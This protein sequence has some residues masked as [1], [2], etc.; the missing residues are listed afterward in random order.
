MNTDYDENELTEKI[1]GSAYNVANTLGYGFLEKV[2]ENSMVI[3]LQEMGLKVESQVPL[4]VFYK[5]KIVGEYVADLIVEDRIV[6]ELKSSKDISESYYA[7]LLNYLKACNKKLGLLINFGKTKV[8]I[9]R[10]KNGY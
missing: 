10:I 1:I 7:Q 6:V 5:E 8:E 9:R 4:S 3:E 2:Y